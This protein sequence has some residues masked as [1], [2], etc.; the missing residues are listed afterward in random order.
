MRT[1]MRPR[2]AGSSRTSKRVLPL[3]TEAAISTASPLP[4][5]GAP[6][7]AITVNVGGA[8]VG[9][10]DEGGCC[11]TA[12][13]WA[14]ASAAVIDVCVLVLVSVAACSRDAGAG[15]AWEVAEAVVS[16]AVRGCG[17]EGSAL[18]VT[19]SCGAA[20]VG[21]AAGFVVIVAV[22]V[23]SV[24]PV[25]PVADVFACTDGDAMKPVV[26]FPFVASGAAV[27]ALRA[28]STA[29]F[30]SGGGSCG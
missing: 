30:G 6:V 4:G 28:T 16:G 1:S 26:V 25:K 20:A 18:A 15:A 13:A 5:T 27:A 7:A 21:D 19:P 17:L 2:S 14:L 29:V 11:T 10:A 3:C 23:E 9:A 24:A 12:A 8:D 22:A